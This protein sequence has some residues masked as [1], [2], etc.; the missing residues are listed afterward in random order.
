M[1]KIFKSN[2]RKIKLPKSRHAA[3]EFGG[4]KKGVLICEN[5]GIFYYKKSWHHNADEFIA[6]RE[7]KDL[8]VGFTFCPAC[9]MIRNKQYEGILLV[10][11]VPANKAGEVIKLIK[12]Y[13]GR[14]YEMDP[15][16]RVIEA[17][18]ESGMIVA[19]TTEN[20][21]AIKLAKKIKDAFNKVK[22]KISFSREPGDVARA[23]VEFLE[24]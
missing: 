16:D 14:A 18:E 4:G 3:E 13:G 23:E 1:A 12:N 24:K 20:E 2:Y 17:R 19:K 5:C 21:L 6:K 22:I 10:K 8:P 7:N 15:L 9:A 11:N